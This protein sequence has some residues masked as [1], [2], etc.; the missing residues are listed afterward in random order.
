MRTEESHTHTE[1]DSSLHR[2]DF[3]T[4][5][6]DVEHTRHQH[7]QLLSALLDI[8][9]IFIL[10]T[11]TGQTD[12]QTRKASCNSHNIFLSFFFAKVSLVF[13]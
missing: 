3:V 11:L 9:F 1:S 6:D 13:I 5:R 4:S 8:I 7:D 10:C 2:V 12:K